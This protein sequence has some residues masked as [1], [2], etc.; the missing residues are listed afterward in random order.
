MGTVAIKWVES[1]LMTGVDSFGHPL[2][3]G[4]WPEREPQ[5]AGLKP[6]DLLMLA[7][8]S[9]SAYDVIM[10]LTKQKEPLEGLEVTCTG[11]QQPEPPYT[12]TTMHL[13]YIFKGNLNPK[14]VERAIKLSEEKYCSVTN[15]L[16]ATV[17]IT[18]SYEI[19]DESLQSAL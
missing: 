15:T 2:T 14:K 5:W 10:I 6:S 16:K 8:A 11:E 1:R 19:I 3:I 7:A 18:N 17:A 12:F 9:C 4:S 13:N